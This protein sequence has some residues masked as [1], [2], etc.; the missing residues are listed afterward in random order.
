MKNE[1]REQCRLVSGT[2]LFSKESL[3]AYNKSYE[4]GVRGTLNNPLAISEDAG[5]YFLRRTYCTMS[6]MS[7]AI[8]NLLINKFITTFS[9]FR[10]RARSPLGSVIQEKFTKIILLGCQNS[11]LVCI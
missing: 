7:N 2:V 10:R 11:S 6:T 3:T 4:I 1:K 9:C 8:L 5:C